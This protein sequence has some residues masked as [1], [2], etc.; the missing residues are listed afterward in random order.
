MELLFLIVGF[1]VGVV[2]R[3]EAKRNADYINREGE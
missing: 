2:Y 1:V 3:E